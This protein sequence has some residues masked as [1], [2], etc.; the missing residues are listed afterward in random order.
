MWPSRKFLLCP[1]V[2]EKLMDLDKHSSI[3]K[4]KATHSSKPNQ[5]I[6]SLL[7]MSREA[8][9]ESRTPSCVTVTWKDK[10][11]S[12]CHS[13]SSFL[14]QYG[15]ADVIPLLPNHPYKMSVKCLQLSTGFI[16]SMTWG[17]TCLSGHLGQEMCAF[18]GGTGHQSQL[19]S[20]RSCTCTTL[21]EACLPLV[22]VV[23]VI[24]IPIM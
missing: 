17:S 23:L 5:R 11:H 1:R 15:Y 2:P 20:D 22:Q 8:F 3:N 14:P 12:K 6:N 21:N 24:G 4:T 10:H 18:R 16:Q 7:P 9:H 13:P 19:R